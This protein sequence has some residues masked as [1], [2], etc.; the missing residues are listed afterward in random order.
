MN[1]EVR[2]VLEA[3][4]SVVDDQPADSPLW[5]ID[6][7]NSEVF[8]TGDSLDLTEPIHQREGPLSSANLVG[9]ATQSREDSPRGVEYNVDV[10]T[11]LSV[12]IEGL[13]A[14]KHGNID[15]HGEHGVPFGDLCEDIRLAIYDDRVYPDTDGR[16]TQFDAQVT[17]IDYQSSDWKDFFRREFDVVL[18]GAEE[19]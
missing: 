7:D 4:E 18:R 6:R 12:R 16:V 14:R 11:V 19:L 9:V 17:N 15:P 8:S 1:A 10:D 3:L 2:W 13:H 5:R